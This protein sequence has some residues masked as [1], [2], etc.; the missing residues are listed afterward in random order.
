MDFLSKPEIIQ[1]PAVQLYAM[2][3]DYERI[4][5][6]LSSRIHDWAVTENGCR[7]NLN[8]MTECTLKLTEK[9]PYSQI[10][11]FIDSDKRLSANVVFMITE[12]G[13]HCNLQMMVSADVPFFMQGIVQK[14][15]EH[16]V[17]SALWQIK[18]SISCA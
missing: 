14:F 11:Y 2:L 18:D 12:E 3:C 9:K 1:M 8:G 7:F 13:N 17:N 16:A 6:M 10:S 4:A 5:R 15:I